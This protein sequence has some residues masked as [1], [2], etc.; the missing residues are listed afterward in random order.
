MTATLIAFGALI[1]VFLWFILGGRR[2]S[3]EPTINR[4]VNDDIDRS[5]LEQ[6]ERDVQDAS[7]EQSVRDWGP[8]ASGPRPPEHL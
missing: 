8:G 7:D 3:H 1:L 2:S 6:A 4:R 5:E